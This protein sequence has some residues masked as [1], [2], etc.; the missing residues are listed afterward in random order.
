MKYETYANIHSPTEVPRR[1]KPICLECDVTWPCGPSLM[2]EQI[3]QL[4][5]RVADLEDAASHGGSRCPAL[6]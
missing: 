4:T 1:R 6:T 5:R 3:E 2:I